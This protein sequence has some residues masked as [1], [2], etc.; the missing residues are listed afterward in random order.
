[1]A[2]RER[3]D[4]GSRHRGRQDSDGLD[5]IDNEELE[6]AKERRDEILS[7]VAHELKALL[8]SLV[9]RAERIA[10]DARDLET[11]H[12]LREIVVKHCWSMVRVIDNL[13]D[14]TR[15]DSGR[16]RIEPRV[17]DITGIVRQTIERVGP[18]CPDH[19]LTM[20]AMGSFEAC[21]DAARIE[22]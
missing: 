17:V 14:V 13:V 19:V 12:G 7:S 3:D 18:T 16:L 15:I 22:Q 6:R 21:V 5:S 4:Q 2:R 1:S 20:T 9:L 8:S 10:P 11:L